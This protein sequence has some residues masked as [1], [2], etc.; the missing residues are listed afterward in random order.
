MKKILILSIASFLC[1]YCKAVNLIAVKGISGTSFFKNIDSAIYYANAGDT[2][3]L[4][5]GGFNISSPIGKEVHIIGAGSDLDSSN[6][7]NATVINAINFN[8]NSSNSSVE[9]CYITNNI[10]S[11]KNLNNIS[12]SRCNVT[13]G[14]K[15]DSF[16]TNFTIK[17]NVFTNGLGYANLTYCSQSLYGLGSSHLISNNIFRAGVF[18]HNSIVRNNILF[19]YNNASSGCF[20]VNGNNNLYENNIIGM[21]NGSNCI[22]KNNI[23]GS[24]IPTID[25]YNNQSINN[26]YF[27]YNTYIIFTG[28]LAYTNNI[29]DYHFAPSNYTGLNF[30]TLGTNGT[31]IGI[32]GGAFPMKAG[33][34]PFNPHF[35]E[36]II[37]S[38]TNPDGT[39]KI[40][41]KVASQE[42]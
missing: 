29:N 13:Y 10:I 21:A 14:M 39:L 26:Y 9:G 20:S 41:L 19:G 37:N 36:A 30:A 17:E 31:E 28:G 5:G 6:A 22:L 38:S 40:Q 33:Q 2:L 18:I 15:I 8:V 34:V 12:I 32:F 25:V 42:R 16:C 4:P 27:N 7:T 11:A 3:Y 35:Q 24:V 23:I 1:Q